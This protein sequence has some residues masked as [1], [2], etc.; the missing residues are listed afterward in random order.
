[1]RLYATSVWEYADNPHMITPYD[2]FIGKE[3]WIKVIISYMHFDKINYVKLLGREGDHVEFDAVPANCIEYIDYERAHIPSYYCFSDG[4]DIWKLRITTPQEVLT[5]AEVQ[6]A[7][8]E[9]D[10]KYRQSEMHQEN[11]E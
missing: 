2:K 9:N 11:M 5:D 10:E 3:Y 1:M 6:E 7:L 4:C 8:A